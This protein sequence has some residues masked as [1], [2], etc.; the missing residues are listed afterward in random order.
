MS[1]RGRGARHKQKAA[2]KEVHQ[3]QRMNS[4]TTQQREHQ[5]N[6][7]YTLHRLKEECIVN[8]EKCGKAEVHM[9][10]QKQ[11]TAIFKDL[12]VRDF[13]ELLEQSTGNPEIEVVGNIFRLKKAYPVVN[14]LELKSYLLQHGRYGIAEDEKFKMCY[15]G[16]I[17]DID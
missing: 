5:I 7:T 10:D 3:V 6:Y 12:T 15:P 14:K 11:I 17:R 4:L 9:N 8:F 1:G 2:E 13:V 16:I